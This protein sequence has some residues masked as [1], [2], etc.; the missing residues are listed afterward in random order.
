ML[1]IG[2]G[3]ALGQSSSSDLSQGVAYPLSGELILYGISLGSLRL[4]DYECQLKPFYSFTNHT[5]RPLFPYA[6]ASSI[7]QPEAT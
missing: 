2:I 1:K 5:W 4:S 3:I 6:S 7:D